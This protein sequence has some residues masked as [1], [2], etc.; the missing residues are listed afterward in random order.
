MKKLIIIASIILAAVSCDIIGEGSNQRDSRMKDESVWLVRSYLV[1]PAY[2]VDFMLLVDDYMQ[3]P[4][5]QKDSSIYSKV[6]DAL[7]KGDGESWLVEDFGILDT[8]GKSLH[9]PGTVWKLDFTD[10]YYGI[11]L[12]GFYFECVSEDLW[13]VVASDDN[14][15]AVSR[16]DEGVLT[17]AT[18]GERKTPDGYDCSFRTEGEFQIILDKEDSRR[19]LSVKGKFVHSVGRG[20][21]VLETC[22]AAYQGNE[23]PAVFNLW[24]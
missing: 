15:T 7:F 24:K 1:L 10:N 13:S 16:G 11:D 6:R 14:V 21:D 3:A 19:C 20:N 17:L 2:Y 22:E 8:R 23:Y 9:E 5:G 18:F 4:E 12:E